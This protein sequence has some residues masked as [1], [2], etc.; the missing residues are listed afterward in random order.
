MNEIQTTFGNLPARQYS[1]RRIILTGM[2]IIV[3]FVGGF[4]LW[5]FIAPL[6]AAVHAQGEVIFDT[7][8]KTVQHLEG[9]IVKQILVR[10][11]DAV[12]AGQP[13][14]L[15]ADDQVRP[16]VDLLENQSLTETATIARL[17]AE[18][19]EQS[20]LS[21]PSTLTSRANDPAVARIMQTETRLFNARRDAFTSQLAILKT[22][23]QQL[24]EELAGLAER[25]VSKKREVA[26]LTEQLA[27]NRE[28]L[29]DG[30]VTRT[31][32][33]DIE[34]M[35]AERTGERD[36][37]VASQAGNR[38]R[39][40]EIDSRE[41]SLKSTRIQDA[42]NEM[43]AATVKRL[44]LEERVRPAINALERQVIRAPIAGRIVD[45]RVTTVGGVIAG[46]EPLM[47][48]APASDHLILEAKIGVNDIHDVRSGQIAE[49]NLTAFK[50]STTPPV[51]ATV[52]QISA[53]RLTSKTMQGEMPY[54]SVQLEIDQ[55]SLK[56]AGNLQLYPGMAAMVSITTRPRTAFD[57]FIGPFTERM[58]RAFHE[59]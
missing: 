25:L 41:I 29:K 37:L 8:R 4:L 47:D 24:K 18:K 3:F 54:Y 17:E 9:G 39:L 34:R 16:T 36:T 20:S 35:L 5:S 56:K 50:T 10:E 23:R 51:K 40:A 53:D 22:Q 52:T 43:K 45:L 2:G 12:T 42:V 48:I 21:F 15:L 26:L 6:E 11:G 31:V 55:D 32:V 19:N 59:K 33:M 57:Y 58:G 46:K 30:Y 13:L 38:Q 44:E 27:F 49:V 7:K 1:P 14:I 28:L